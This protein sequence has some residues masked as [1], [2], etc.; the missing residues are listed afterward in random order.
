MQSG[1]P[2]TSGT[3]GRGAGFGGG[4]GTGGAAGTGTV[5]A[6][7]GTG[8]VCGAG[9]GSAAAGLPASSPNASQPCVSCEGSGAAAVCGGASAGSGT[10]SV[11]AGGPPAPTSSS[12]AAQGEDS[13]PCT[14]EAWAPTGENPD[15]R[16]RRLPRSGAAAGS[17]ASAELR[18]R[19]ACL[20]SWLWVG[21]P[22]GVGMVTSC[23]SPRATSEMSRHRLTL[24]WLG[25]GRLRGSGP[26]SRSAS[27]CSGPAHPRGVAR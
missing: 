8:S 2:R 16:S 19:M 1:P 12:N 10:C 26:R 11:G 5:A 18:V 20:V 13:S 21:G 7:A 22:S 14:P 15:I 23:S 4:L 27:A 24:Q 6:G 3:S 9:A 17:R 25:L